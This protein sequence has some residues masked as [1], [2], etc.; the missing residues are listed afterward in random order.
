MFIV[1]QFVCQNKKIII[2]TFQIND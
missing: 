1:N 2:F